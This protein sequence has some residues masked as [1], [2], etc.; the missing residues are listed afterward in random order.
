MLTDDDVQEIV[1]LLDDLQYDELH[2]TT[3]HFTLSLRRSGPDGGWSRA[4]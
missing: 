4:S 1:R 3:R 2:L